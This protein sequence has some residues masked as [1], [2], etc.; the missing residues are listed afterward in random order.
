MFMF[1]LLVGVSELA[2]S[3]APPPADRFATA[4]VRALASGEMESLA[5]LAT[6]EATKSDDWQLLRTDLEPYDCI[7]IPAHRVAIENATATT[8]ELLVTMEATAVARGVGRAPLRFPSRWRIHLVGDS[9][10]WKLQSVVMEERVIA[11][12][13]I[14]QPELSSPQIEAIGENA[15]LET[16]LVYLCDELYLPSHATKMTA[17]A[18]VIRSVAR[19]HGLTIA[20]VACLRMMIRK[21]IPAGQVTRA[22]DFA[23]EAVEIAEA[24]GIPDAQAAALLASGTVEWANGRSEVALENYGA[25]A[26][27]MKV[28]DDPRAPMKALYMRGRLLVSRGEYRAALI[29]SAALDD[30]TKRFGWAEGRCVAAIQ[31]TELFNAL[32]DVQTARHHAAEALRCSERLGKQEFMLI[33]LANLATAELAAGNRAVAAQ[34]TQRSIDRAPVDDVNRAVVASA[35]RDLAFVLAE[36]ERYQDAESELLT[37]LRLARDS[38]EKPLEADI[39]QVLARV[40]LMLGRVEEALRGAEEADVLIRDASATVRL[41]RDNADWAVRATLGSALRAAGKVPQAIAALQSSIELIESRRA[42]L[43][44]DELTV[45][46]FMRDKAQP[47][48]ELISLLVEQGRPR[49]AVVISERFRAGALGTSV[50]RGHIDML[51]SMGEEESAQ[52]DAIND[53]ISS[54]NRKLLASSDDP[55]NAALREQLAQSRLKQRTFL[56]RLYAGNPDIRERRIEDPQEVIGDAQRLLPNA[57]EALLTFSVQDGETF[58]FYIE[59]LGND[60]D[61]SVQRIPIRKVDLET[62]VRHFVRQIE[63]R[64][65]DYRRTSRSLYDLLVA[66]FAPRIAAKR[67]LYVVPDGTL[68]RLPFQALQRPNGKHLIELVALAYAP[69]LTL[70]RNE[71]GDD[72]SRATSGTLLAIADPVLEQSG[73][74]VVRATLRGRDLGAL[75]DA[76][77]EVR[78]IQRTYGTNSRVLIGADATETAVK[79]LAGTFRILHVATHGIIDDGAPMYSALVLAASGADDGLL[80]AREMMNLDLGADLAIL[81]A[82]ESAGGDLTP[83]EGIIGM[84]WALMVAG[85][86]NT[87]VSQWKVE[88]RSTAALMIAFHREANRKDVDHASALRRAQL[89]LMRTSEFSHPY[90]WS[91]FV[92]VSTSQ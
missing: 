36:Q 68:W 32:Q 62:R 67:L 27:L 47:Y 34:L 92:L 73:A 42:A 72:G 6:N 66:P 39:L 90:Y 84:S 83:G 28:V 24:N 81:S 43:G 75:P 5:A 35:R 19:T 46:G 86:R 69:S 44:T 53:S 89:A 18:E 78:E 1:L 30:A 52:Y 16:L 91:P 57:N 60:L 85:C 77:T 63:R 12:H 13:L 64:D 50:A 56:S 40:R 2:P 37:A 31:S 87:V 21:A 79:Q 58:A 20:E 80:E 3:A 76:R 26:A 61:V 29:S 38:H 10:D 54:L 22:S 49:D 41:S 14:S 51:P 33:S 71:R 88:S 15:D 11:R 45:S 70:L 59:R 9:G 23:R 7:S 55:G 48:R 4:F 17:G 74:N 65:L 82:C 25:A 8:L